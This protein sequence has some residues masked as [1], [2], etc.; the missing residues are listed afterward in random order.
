MFEI[1]NMPLRYQLPTPNA[2]GWVQARK[3]LNAE[4]TRL[5][6]YHRSNVSFVNN[7]NILVQLLADL[8]IPNG[9]LGSVALE[10]S[11]RFDNKM[12]GL[13]IGSVF[14][15]PDFSLN[16]WFYNKR[17]FEILLQ[18]SSLFDADDVYTNWQDARPI[19]ILHHPFND[20]SLA[21][22]NGKYVSNEE[23]G[24]AVITI[25]P[26]MLAIQYKGYLDWCMEF[27]KGMINAPAIYVSQFPIFNMLKDHI[28]IALRNRLIS[29]YNNEPLAPFRSAYSTAIN[30][31]TM[32]VNAALASVIK[33]ING[34]AFKF[35]RVLEMMPAFSRDT[36]RE[37]TAFPL[38]AMTY[39]TNWIYEVARAPLLDFLVR[40]GQAN[41]NYQNLDVINQIKRSI[42]EMINDKSIPNNASSVS[43]KYIEDLERLTSVV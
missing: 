35:D 38:N 13:G 34:Q 37:I 12:T 4:Y 11:D 18:D 39:S 10:L 40:Y 9:E 27:N 24:Y 41:P 16:S 43:R 20:M 22:P 23:P 21:Y 28:D 31:P 19:R 3:V 25:N 33:N 8:Q 36:Q 29:M 26:A 30:N 2:T 5:E 1:F 15:R 7:Q 14:G 17:T 32:Y 6:R 42:T